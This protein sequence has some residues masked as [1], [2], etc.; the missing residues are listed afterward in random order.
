MR[1]NNYL[2][3]LLVSNWISSV[4][5]IW[6]L[7]LSLICDLFIHYTANNISFCLITLLVPAFYNR[8]ILEILFITVLT[9]EAIYF[10]RF[11]NT[12]SLHKFSYKAPLAP[13]QLL[14]VPSALIKPLF[15]F[16][17]HLFLFSLLAHCLLSKQ[18]FSIFHL[19]CI[20][21]LNYIY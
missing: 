4:Q 6:L 11:N 12:I 7:L 21:T 8:I 15:S 5:K 18:A 2:T 3:I 9:L 17:V 1:M 10:I 19:S 20:S 13:P 14:K 16:I